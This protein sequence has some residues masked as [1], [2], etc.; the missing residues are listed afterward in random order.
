MA[1]NRQILNYTLPF[2][3]NIAM[4]DSWIGLNAALVGKYCFLPQQ[5]VNYRRHGNNVTISFKKND[6]PVSYQIQYRLTMMYHIIKRRFQRKF[7]G[8]N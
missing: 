7:S 6:L 4:H 5:L 8:D 1:L 2:P 3:P